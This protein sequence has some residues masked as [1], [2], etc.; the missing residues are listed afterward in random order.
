MIAH[1][2]I[3][4]RLSRTFRVVGRKTTWLR[5]A[6]GGRQLM[7][8]ASR[9]AAQRPVKGRWLRRPESCAAARPARP[10]LTPRG[11]LA[12][13]IAKHTRLG[14]QSVD[15]SRLGVYRSAGRSVMSDAKQIL[16]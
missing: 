14:S 9:A 6:L 8:R 11:M 1:N 15:H 5:S 13:Q 12:K 3:A 2:F 10:H 4:R 7:G 16:D